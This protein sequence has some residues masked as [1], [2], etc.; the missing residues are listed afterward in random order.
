MSVIIATRRAWRSGPQDTESHSCTI[1]Q[2]SPGTDQAGTEGQDI[3]MVVLTA[4]ASRREVV[5]EGGPDTRN[6]VGHHR[7]ADAGPVDDDAPVTRAVG[8]ATLD[9]MGELGIVDR[10]VAVGATIDHVVT[11]VLELGHQLLFEVEAAMVGPDGYG[12]AAPVSMARSGWDGAIRV[13]RSRARAQVRIGIEDPIHDAPDDVTY[14]GFGKRIV[15]R[16]GCKSSGRIV[17]R[18]PRHPSTGS[19]KAKQPDTR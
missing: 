18:G 7:R 12:L 5:A 4:V 10:L 11:G 15:T 14:F 19:G 6:L 16:H 1:C 8:D 3:G 2:A 17:I 9:R 13:D